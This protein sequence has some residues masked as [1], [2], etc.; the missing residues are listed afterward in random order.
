MAEPLAAE[1][2]PPSGTPPETWVAVDD[3][4][5]QV[6]LEAISTTWPDGRTN[7][8]IRYTSQDEL[9]APGSVKISF[10]PHANGPW[11]TIAAG[12]DAEGAHRWEPERSAPPRAFIR[13]EARDVAGNTG[14]AVTAEP[15]TVSAARVIGHLRGLREL[16]APG[17]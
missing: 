11:S 5:P 7:I 13:V 3:V 2:A 15:V 8:E 4:A 14:H 6:D 17:G 16:P 12:L 1:A 9:L 10:S